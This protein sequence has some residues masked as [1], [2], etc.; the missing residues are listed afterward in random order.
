MIVRRSIFMG[1]PLTTVAR[2]DRD[3]ATKSAAV[4]ALFEHWTEG[5]RP[6][7]AVG[8]FSKGEAVHRKCY[9]FANLSTG[10][11][12]HSKSPFRLAS[13]TKPFVAMT[14][15]ILGE[16]GALKYDDPIIRHLPE[17]SSYGQIGRA[18]V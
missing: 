15:M 12:I 9:G 14:I 1:D 8:I 13:L 5:R 18:H 2:R 7:G 10:T 16:R 3:P 17:F 6:G 11:E 4:D